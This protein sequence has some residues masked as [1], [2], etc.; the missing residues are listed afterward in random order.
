MKA[1]K[2]SQK[3][4]YLA[5]NVPLFSEILFVYKGKLVLTRKNSQFAKSVAAQSRFSCNN[6]VVPIPKS[7]GSSS[8]THIPSAGIKNLTR[9]QRIPTDGASVLTVLN[10][11]SSSTSIAYTSVGQKVSQEPETTCA[12]KSLNEQ[13][14][15]I[16]CKFQSSR[17]EA[18]AEVLKRKKLEADA[19]EAMR[20]VKLYFRRWSFHCLLS[21]IN[22]SYN[23]C[24]LTKMKLY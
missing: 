19:A 12:E 2:S 6:E 16:E 20:K 3:A 11:T 18:F 15:D 4:S 7:P 22:Y 13:L 10:P 17:Y 1:K 23:F 21:L 8:V 14:A 9:V 24:I 5:R